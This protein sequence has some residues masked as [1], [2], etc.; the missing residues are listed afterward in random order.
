[1]G[2]PFTSRLRVLSRRVKGA[3]ISYIAICLIASDGTAAPG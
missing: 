2:F 3:V 1:M